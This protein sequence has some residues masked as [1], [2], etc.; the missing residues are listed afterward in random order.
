M[1]KKSQH[2]LLKSAKQKNRKK[3]RPSKGLWFLG[4][5]FIFTGSSIFSKKVYYYCNSYSKVRFS[6]RGSFMKNLV[7]LGEFYLGK[8][9]DPK[10]RKARDELLLYPSKNLTTHTV[11]VGM[12]GSGK[13]GLGISIL[14]EAGLDKIPAIIIDPKGDLTNLLLTFPEL[15]PKD[16]RPWIDESE[17][18]RKG[19]KL[20]EY[21]EYMAQTWKDGLASSG[22]SVDRIKK[23]RDSVEFE[24]YTPASKLG[25]PISI[26]NSFGA[27]PKEQLLDT[28]SIREKVQSLTSSLLGLLGIAADPIKSREHILLSTLINQAWQNGTDLDIP[29]LIQ[30]VQKPP[31]TT[32]GALPV[33]TFYPSKERMELSISLNNLL[34][35]PGFQ[36]WMEGDPLD[37]NHLLYTKEGKPKLSIISIMH[38]SDSERMFFVTLLLNQFLT[39]MR[40]QS[41]TTSL[42]ALLYMDEIFGFFPPTATPPSKLPMLTLLKQARAFGVGIFLVTQNPVDLD[43]K[44]LSNCGTWFIGKLQTDRDKARIIE[45][46]KV[47]SNGEID[48]KNL[49]SML[50]M[51]GNRTFIMR[52]IYEKDTILFQTRWTLSFLRGPL[53]L[54]QIA[55]LTAKPIESIQRNPTTL[56]EKSLKPNS[57]PNVPSGITEYFV[58]L[59]NSRL[60]VHYEPRVAGI[61]KLHF[62][63]SKYNIDTWEE[64]CLTVTADDDGHNINWEKGSNIPELKNRLENA[65]VPDSSFDNLPVGLMLEKNYLLFEKKLAADLY[66]NQTYTIYNAPK[67]NMISK[68]GESEGD[69]RARAAQTMREK[70]DVLVKKVREKYS[71][72]IAVLTNRLQRFQEKT[73]EKK[74]KAWLQKFQTFISFLTTILGAFMSG[75]KLTKGTISQAGTSLRRAGQVGKDSQDATQAESD[76]NL[77]RQQLMD[78]ESE[79]NNEISSITSSGNIDNIEIEKVSIRPRKSDISVEKVA[80][81]WWPQETGG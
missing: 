72:K 56:I 41:G 24:I 35:S 42:R 54:K 28:A 81:V 32:I 6:N 31:F 7:E 76:F 59:S 23:L 8:V 71:G 33:D 9:V 36:V 11:C 49:D 62:I 25:T 39:W 75:R 13:T 43:Y 21:S 47:A 78:L 10:T 65:P 18:E 57:K 52:S 70:L 29:L 66:Q 20:D 17:A 22:E 38:L 19:M 63:D 51:T 53:T 26:L 14:E 2:L 55:S 61:S 44:G 40:Q 34:A 15:S 1:T 50:A 80:L 45:G 3:N 48:A 37:I 12:T 77:I 58:R 27:P 16:F 64:I 73:S 30:Q 79:M 60:P 69:F 4:R 74:Q 5:H 67:L 68:A 46:L